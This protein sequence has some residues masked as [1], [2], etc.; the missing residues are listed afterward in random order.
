MRIVEKKVYKYEELDERAKE[1]ARDWYREG[2]LSY[3][4]WDDIY[5]DAANVADILGINL[6]NKIVKLM[7]GMFRFDPEIYFSGFSHQGQ[8]SSFDGEY[9]YA[10]G[11]TKKIRKFAPQD[12]EL[13]RIADALQE[14]QRRH[15]YKL[16]AV[17]IPRRDTD[18]DV[19]VHKYGECDYVNAP[20]EITDDLTDILRDFNHWIFKCLEREYEHLMSDECVEENIIA[21]EYEFDEEGEIA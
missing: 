20:R 1:K 3:D 21:N 16:W 5:E 9:H 2:C 14:L 18:I 6:R 19:A 13:H 17:A 4:W 11:A 8:G 10:K 12:T 15:F 7:N